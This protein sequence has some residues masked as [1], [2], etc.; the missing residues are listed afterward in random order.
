MTGVIVLAL[1][2]ASLSVLAARTRHVTIRAVAIGTI[3]CGSF[4]FSFV[5][6]RGIVHRQ[7]DQVHSALDVAHCDNVWISAQLAAQE[8]L[9]KDALVLL[10]ANAALAIIAILPRRRSGSA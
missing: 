2:L 7:L 6:N 4:L 1:A 10:A 5:V 3:L 8:R 9:S